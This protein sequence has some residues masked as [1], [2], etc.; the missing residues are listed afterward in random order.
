MS[1][2]A[3]AGPIPDPTAC[4]I[5]HEPTTGGS[6]LCSPCAWDRYDDRVKEWNDD[7]REDI[8]AWHDEAS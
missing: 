2:Y 3:T 8:A 5:C 6:A 1:A 4:D 7:L